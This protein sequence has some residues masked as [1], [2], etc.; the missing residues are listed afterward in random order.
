MVLKEHHLIKTELTL[1]DL[2][3]ER[4]HRLFS[5]QIGPILS[6]IKNQY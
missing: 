6:T 5:N 2:S 4:N 3:R 1:P